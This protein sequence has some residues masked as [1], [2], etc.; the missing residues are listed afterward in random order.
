VRLS[1]DSEGKYQDGS[2]IVV[3][4]NLCGDDLAFDEEGSAYIAT[5]PEQTVIKLVGLGFGE[6]KSRVTILGG[7]K[8]A[9]SAGPTAVAFGRGGIGRRCMLLR[10]V[11]W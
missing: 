5:N 7:P 11:A 8:V 2:V 1:V 6:K 4:E 10:L 9:E 3:A